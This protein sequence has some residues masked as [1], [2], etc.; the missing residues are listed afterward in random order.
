[1]TT[2]GDHEAIARSRRIT[3]KLHGSGLS[4]SYILNLGLRSLQ[5]GLCSLPLT[6]TQY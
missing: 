1:M 6:V 2:S 4:P 5:P 3:G